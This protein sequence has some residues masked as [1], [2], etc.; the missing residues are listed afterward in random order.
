MLARGGG[1]VV[2]VR[3]TIG[4][5]TVVVYH[6]SLWEYIKPGT[7]LV[8]YLVSS[9]HHVPDI[10]NIGLKSSYTLY[11]LFST[12]K[13]K[14]TWFLKIICSLASHFFKILGYLAKL[15]MYFYYFL[16]TFYG[17]LRATRLLAVILSLVNGSLVCHK[18]GKEYRSDNKKA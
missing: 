6:M 17:Q 1:V 11:Y 9:A 18:Q 12:N 15:S 2:V 14:L 16:V 13:K 3:Y 7:L 8:P 4:V 5:K 10:A